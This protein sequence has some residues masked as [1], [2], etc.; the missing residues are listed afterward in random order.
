MYYFNI[1]LEN[2]KIRNLVFGK[3]KGIELAEL[4]EWA[5]KKEQLRTSVFCRTPVPN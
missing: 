4:Q 5:N 1:Y 3:S 2:A